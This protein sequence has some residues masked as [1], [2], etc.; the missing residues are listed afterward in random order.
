[1]MYKFLLGKN[2]NRIYVNVKKNLA[3]VCLS[4]LKIQYNNDG[5]PYSQSFHLF[6]RLELFLIP[7]LVGHLEKK[8]KKFAKICSLIKYL[9]ITYLFSNSGYQGKDFLTVEKNT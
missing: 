3:F 5:F 2:F 7:Y 9:F 1:M 8:K 4:I 6:Q